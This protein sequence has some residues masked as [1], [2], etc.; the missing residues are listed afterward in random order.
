MKSISSFLEY[1]GGE[2]VPHVLYTSKVPIKLNGKFHFQIFGSAKF[3]GVTV[4][5]TSITAILENSEL[6]LSKDAS[7]IFHRSPPLTRITEEN[8]PVPDL[9]DY[10]DEATASIAAM[11]EDV[12]NKRGYFA[13]RRTTDLDD[14]EIDDD[15]DN[16][17]LPVS[18]FTLL[19]NLE[20]D[21]HET[22]DVIENV[23][24]HGDIQP[25][26]PKN[27]DKV[28]DT[29]EGQNVGLRDAVEAPAA[30]AE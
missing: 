12:L 6:V 5:D 17:G 22:D 11:I 24:V 27:E 18:S 29:N 16:T 4:R 10:E 26:E 21:I 14:D 2:V 28:E 23:N 13:D 7:V 15:D 3:N 19:E 9:P 20:A 1:T 8:V 25:S 30:V